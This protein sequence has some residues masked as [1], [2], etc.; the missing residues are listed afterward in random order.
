MND[1]EANGTLPK[2][3]LSN[4]P[5]DGQRVIAP[6]A[7]R[8]DKALIVRFNDG[9]RQAFEE[10]VIRYQQRIYNT[11]L[12]FLRVDDEAQ[13]VTQE[14]FIKVYHALP[15][16]RGE[17][18]FST[19]LY[20]VAMNHCK[21]KLKYLKRRHYYTSDSMEQAIETQDGEMS[22]QFAS[23]DPDPQQEAQSR[24]TQEKVRAAINLLADDQREVIVLRELQ[25][26]SYEEIA[27]ITGQALGTVKSRIHRARLE[28][29][30]LLKPLL[31]I[32]CEP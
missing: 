7:D 4:Q 31:E 29:A 23:E 9:D 32:E 22:R 17:S 21:N 15:E 27:D 6:D 12:R 25:G 5:V 16:F 11:A 13:E 30:R 18:K 3:S 19:W 28:L 2:Q 1:H 20:Q 24:E 26:L 8:A 10:L 14:I